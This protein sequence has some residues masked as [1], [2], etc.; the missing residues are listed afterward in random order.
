MFDDLLKLSRVPWP[1][2]VNITAK[3]SNPS[4]AP[5]PL[6]LAGPLRIFLL[7]PLFFPSLSLMLPFFLHLLLTR[8]FFRSFPFHKISPLF[9]P[10]SFLPYNLPNFLTFFPL[11]YLCIMGCCCVD[12][13]E[14]DADTDAMLWFRWIGGCSCVIKAWSDVSSPEDLL[15]LGI[16]LTSVVHSI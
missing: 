13:E 6:T 14:E 15:C 16:P 2:L 9:L 11:A 7:L 12:E 3:T 5:P 4:L 1:T 10:L 8:P